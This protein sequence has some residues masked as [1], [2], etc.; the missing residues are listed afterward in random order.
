MGDISASKWNGREKRKRKRGGKI[1]GCK[2][3]RSQAPPLNKGQNPRLQK[4]DC[5]KKPS[6][7]PQGKG[8]GA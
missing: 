1:I 4:G 5:G 7:F 6:L 8:E 3:W 2:T